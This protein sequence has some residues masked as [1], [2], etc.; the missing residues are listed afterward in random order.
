MQRWSSI[1]LECCDMWEN[2]SV[3]ICKV[4]MDPFSGFFRGEKCIVEKDAVSLQERCYHLRKSYVLHLQN[5]ILPH[6]RKSCSPLISIRNK[7]RCLWS[8]PLLSAMFAKVICI[9]ASGSAYE[10]FIGDHPFCY[11]YPKWCS[12]GCRGSCVYQVLLACLPL[13]Y[14]LR[15]WCMITLSQAAKDSTFSSPMGIARENRS[16]LQCIFQVLSS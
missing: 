8:F 10:L 9:F 12:R 15:T 6:K 2:K 3:S 7:C 4:C 11:F 1:H 5:C 13:T 14:W 16:Y